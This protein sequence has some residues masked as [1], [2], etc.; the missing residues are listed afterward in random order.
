[1]KCEDE[2]AVSLIAIDRERKIMNELELTVR[3]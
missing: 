3:K 1:M 2:I